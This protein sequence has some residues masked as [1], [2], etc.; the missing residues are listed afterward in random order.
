MGGATHE[1]NQVLQCPYCSLQKSNRTSHTDPQTGAAAPLFHPLTQ[2]WKQHFRMERSGLC[3]GLTPTG[4][5]TVAALG[6][7]DPLPRIAREIQIELGI[8][9]LEQ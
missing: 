8:L 9:P 3:V 4:R 7:N 5:A 2:D 6:I 1:S